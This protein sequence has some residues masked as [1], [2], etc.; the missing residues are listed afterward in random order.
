ML[1]MVEGNTIGDRGRGSGVSHVREARGALQ[2]RWKAMFRWDLV[3]QWWRTNVIVIV[4]IQVTAA[5][6]IRGSFMFM[7]P[8]VL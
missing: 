6:E 4:V 8:T 2:L 1:S 3:F 7:R 5:I